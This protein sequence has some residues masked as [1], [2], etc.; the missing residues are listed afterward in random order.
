LDVLGLR[1]KLVIVCFFRVRV[2]DFTELS[3]LEKLPVVQLLKNFPAFYGMQ[4]FIT[5]FR[6]ALN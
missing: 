6:R 3:L 1:E 5:V 2:A 4:R